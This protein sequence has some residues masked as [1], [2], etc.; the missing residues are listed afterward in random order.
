MCTSTNQGAKSE[1]YLR[2]SETNKRRTAL[3]NLDALKQKFAGQIILPEIC[4]N[5]IKD[6]FTVICSKHGKLETTIFNLQGKTHACRFCAL[7]RIKI[8]DGKKQ[9]TNCSEWKLLSEYSP[10]NKTDIAGEKI[11]NQWCKPCE[12][13]Y[14]KEQAKRRRGNPD[15]LLK[16]KANSVK[17]NAK[18]A[19]IKLAIQLDSGNGPSS[20][21]HLKRCVVCNKAWVSK[22][23]IYKDTCSLK[24]AVLYRASKVIGRKI[25]RTEKQYKCRQCSKTFI[26]KA[27]GKCN[28]CIKI[29]QKAV[30]KKR[31]VAIRSVAIE[32][33]VDIKVFVS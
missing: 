2:S 32:T 30:K 31:R 26:G 10:T 27:P 24:C 19:Q 16:M 5:S 18:K 8:V 23:P 15:S 11:Y 4:P 6:S 7:K 20:P 22:R 28:E 21:L 12:K 25:E 14:R 17:H 33:V 13:N 1:R 29:F 9:C 3:K